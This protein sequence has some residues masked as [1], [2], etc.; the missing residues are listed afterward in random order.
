MLRFQTAPL[1][2]SAAVASLVPAQAVS[3]TPPAARAQA[4]V[5]LRGLSAGIAELTALV[6]PSVVQVLVT[7]FRPLEDVDGA[8]AVGRFHGSGSGVIVDAAGYIVTNAH[9]I[10][11]ADRIQVV[12]HAPRTGASPLE[13][14]AS[15]HG[16]AISATVVGVARDVDLAVLKVDRDG[17]TPM[18]FAD[19]DTVRQGELVFAFGSP[20]GLRDSVSMGV[21]STTARLLTPDSP[22]VFIQTDAPIN[23]GNSGGPLANVHGEL[24]GVNA[25]VMS[26]TGGNQGLGFAIPSAVVASTYAQLR[27]YGHPNRGTIGIQVQAVTPALAEGLHLERSSGVVISDVT[28]HSPADL[29]GLSVRDIVL[30]LNQRPIDSVPL[31]RLATATVQPSDR[32]EIDVLRGTTTRTV[33][34]IVGENPNRLDALSDLADPKRDAVPAL[35]ILGADLTPRVRGFLPALRIPS[36]VLVVARTQ[37]SGTGSLLLPGDLIHSLNTFA[38]SSLAALQVLTEGIAPHSELV[39][40]IEREGHLQ[41]VVVTTP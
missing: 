2:L 8:G 5:T 9:V 27:K 41:Y 39:L 17:L 20:V 10:E 1:L 3:Q 6:G 16:R 31:L 4:T 36:G 24:V 22:A 34:I 32:V 15:D 35:G 7:G 30:R 21:V 25:L 11:G 18:R 29:A 14:L 12:L 37:G 23:P 28:P 26:P 33:Q 19:Y 38:V 40:Q 13:A